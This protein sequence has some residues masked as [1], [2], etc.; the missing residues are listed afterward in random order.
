M[1]KK[2]NQKYKEEIEEFQNMI[3]EK[4][5]DEEEIDLDAYT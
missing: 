1:Q 5:M 2:E 3:N 4:Q